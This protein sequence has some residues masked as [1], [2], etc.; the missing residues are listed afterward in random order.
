[1]KDA[2]PLASVT[3]FGKR[4]GKSAG[5]MYV[6]RHRGKL[7]PATRVDRRLYWRWEVIEAWLESRT[8]GFEQEESEERDGGVDCAA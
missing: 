1:M 8:E 7:P 6:L 5:Y 3:D 4:I 2:R